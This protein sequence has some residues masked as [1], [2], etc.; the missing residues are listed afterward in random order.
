MALEFLLLNT[1]TKRIESPTDS[2]LYPSFQSR[3]QLFL[4]AV[5]ISMHS[6]SIV[7]FFRNLELFQTCPLYCKLDIFKDV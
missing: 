2:L 5:S 1:L 4:N 7:T 6:S 3:D